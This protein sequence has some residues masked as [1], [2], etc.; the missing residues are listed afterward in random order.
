MALAFLPGRA[1][2][3]HAV[4]HGHIVADLGRFA[5]H[6][7][8]AVVDKETPPDGRPRMDLDTGEPA[9]KVRNEARQPFEIGMPQRIGQAM[10]DARMQARIAGQHLKGGARRGVAVE[11]AGNI[12]S[13]VFEHL[14][15]LPHNVFSGEHCTRLLPS[16]CRAGC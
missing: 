7:A 5:D 15:V 8:H 12:F 6:H 1:A 10:E 16:A 11:Y 14:D 13:K 3:R 9:R 2:Q 4:I